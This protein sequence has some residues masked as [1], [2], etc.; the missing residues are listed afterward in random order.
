MHLQQGIVRFVSRIMSKDK[1]LPRF[2]TREQ[3]AERLGLKPKTLQNW[4]NNGKGP[5]S[6]RLEG[7]F[8]VYKTEDV[9]AWLERQGVSS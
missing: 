5:R 3:L 6:Y 4:A 9:S 7:G 8:A 2:L 1:S